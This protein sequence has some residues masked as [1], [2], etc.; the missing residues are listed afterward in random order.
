MKQN[1]RTFGLAIGAGIAIA[2][3]GTVYLSLENKIAGSLLFTIGLYTIMLNGL[4]LFTGKIGYF[5]IREDKK[6]YLIMLVVTWLGNLAGTMIG[7]ILLQHTR[8]QGVREKAAGICEIKLSDNVLSIFFLA[9][10]CG[11]LMYTAVEGYRQKE[12]PLILFLCISV[13]I[14]CG[15]EH[16]I[17]NMFYFTLAGMWSLKTCGYLLVMTL[18]N[19]LGGMLI[20]SIKL[21]MTE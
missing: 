3:G 12:N 15:F 1:I 8:V 14:L 2:I 4:F 21:K 16:C 20:P 11:I 9:I 19:S 10:F 5:V 7:A 18:G 13:F 6:S 17:A